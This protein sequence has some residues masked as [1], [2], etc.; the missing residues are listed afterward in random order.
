[1]PPPANDSTWAFDELIE[2]PNGLKEALIKL[3]AFP[4]EPPGKTDCIWHRRA[5]GKFYG[6]D[7]MVDKDVGDAFAAFYALNGHRMFWAAHPGFRTLLRVVKTDAQN[8]L[9]KI[10]NP[11]SRPAHIKEHIHEA[12]KIIKEIIL[13]YSPQDAFRVKGLMDATA[14]DAAHSLGTR[15][16]HLRGRMA[17]IY[18]QDVTG[19][20]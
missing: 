4:G 5:D 19:A 17:K 16:S 2:G 6:E 7:G 20:V 15:Q 14:S 13:D 1:M 9:L 11:E 8:A 12:C 10:K 18:R 3:I